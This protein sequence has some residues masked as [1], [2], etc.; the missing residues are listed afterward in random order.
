MKLAAA[1]LLVAGCLQIPE[2][3]APECTQ[4]ADCETSLGE[5]CNA[6]VCYGGP[7]SG[8]FAGVLV[9]P[10]TRNDLA[11]YEIPSIT[12]PNDGDFGPITFDSAVR[13]TGRIEA[14]C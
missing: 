6:G 13:L 5:V 3:A 1:C 14:A 2:P 8:Q 12:L 10:S 4:N 11:S 7:P 9:P